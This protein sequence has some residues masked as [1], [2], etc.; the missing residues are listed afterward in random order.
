MTDMVEQVALAIW[1]AQGAPHGL[2]PVA[3]E[4]ERLNAVARAAIAAMGTQWQPIATAPREDGIEVLTWDGISIRV[5]V[6]AYDDKWWTLGLPAF[7]PS[8]WM[9]LPEPPMVNAALEERK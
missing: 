2:F 9:P 3:S 4:Q 7:V 8:H 6:R 5:A 1:H